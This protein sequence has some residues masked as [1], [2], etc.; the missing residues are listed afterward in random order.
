MQLSKEEV[1]RIIEEWCR[2]VS[3]SDKERHT[4]KRFPLAIDMTRKVIVKHTRGGATVVVAEL[5]TESKVG[6]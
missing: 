6:T 1:E 5:T 2:A 3:Y 4:T